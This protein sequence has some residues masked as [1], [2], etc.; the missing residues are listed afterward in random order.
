V[1]GFLHWA[2]DEL[3]RLS[4]VQRATK[5]RAHHSFGHFS[6]LDSVARLVR[7]LLCIQVP[8]YF[9]TCCISCFNHII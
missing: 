3:G 4:S 9:I 2:T 5:E 1:E 8:L 6:S 7:S